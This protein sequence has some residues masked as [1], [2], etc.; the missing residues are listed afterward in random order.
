[1]LRESVLWVT[2]PIKS[3]SL[4]PVADISDAHIDMV[5]HDARLFESEQEAEP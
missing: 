3:I 2:R 4:E 5:G 1:M